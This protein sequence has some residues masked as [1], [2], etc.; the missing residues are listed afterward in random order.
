MLLRAHIRLIGVGDGS[1]VTLRIISAITLS[2]IVLAAQEGPPNEP[3][4]LA[5]LAG[6]VKQVGALLRGG[7][8]PNQRDDLGRTPLMWA[9]FI[10][11]RSSME[12]G[13]P[14][15]PDYPEV[16]RLLLDK[17][18]DVNARDSSGRTALLMAM[19]GAA[20]EYKVFGADE[21]FARLLIQ[22]GAQLNLQDRDG[23]SPLLK[24]VS[25]WADQPKLISHLIAR[26]ADVNAHLKDGRTA[27]M[28]AARLGKDDRMTVLID[29]GADVNA[30]D[31]QGE[32]ALTV[33]TL[34]G[35]DDGSLQ[36]IK[37][38]LAHGAN[39]N[40]SDLK[41]QTAADLAMEAGRIDRVQFLL[42]N[43]AR[44]ADLKAFLA[45]GRNQALCREI[46]EGSVEAAKALLDE[47]GDPNYRNANG[48]TLLMIAADNEYSA[49]KVTLLLQHGAS[50]NV[51]GPARE[52]A[53]MVAA[54]RYQAE[55]VSALL[56][57]GADPNAAD[58]SGNSVLL[59][60]AASRQA[61]HEEQHPLIHLLVGKGVDVNRKNERGVTALMLMAADGNPALGLLLEKHA[62]VNA[63]DAQGDTALLYGARFFVRGWQRR[64]GWALLENG[65]DVNAANL[66][67]ETAL[68][69]AAT[70][71]EAD[72]VRLLLDKGAKVNA[73]SSQGRTALMQAIDGPKEFDNQNHVVYSPA[74]AKVLIDAG[75]DVNARDNDDNTPLSLAQGRGYREMVDTLKKAGAR[76]Q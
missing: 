17:G 15:L 64:D 24:A 46:T 40:H 30:A 21:D 12:T 1:E 13:R 5:A 70:Q 55:I 35:W 39:P 56:E 23:W 73:K 61:W 33:A 19:E 34:V 27:L 62:E 4:S 54:D 20:S 57:H 31:E 26:G 76:E 45:R 50:V 59:H 43:G 44:V 53:L 38:L 11:R 75:A 28:L 3:L 14:E 9:A 74:I 47:G 71:Y 2:V 63:R 7:A 65:A 41:G 72:A 29:K 16:A 51:E 52:T 18:A 58:A 37:L 22:R 66:R 6:D 68:I 36:M 69:L 10:L 67:G 60:A 32:T 25:L 42:K 8:D 49:A 48:R